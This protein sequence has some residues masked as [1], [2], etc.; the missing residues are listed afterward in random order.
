MIHKTLAIISLA[1]TLIMGA[2]QKIP[3]KDTAV[4]DTIKKDTLKTAKPLLPPPKKVEKVRLNIDPVLK[5]EPSKYVNFTSTKL[6]AQNGAI[7]FQ[8]DFLVLGEGI[9]GHFDLQTFD[10]TGNRLKLAQSEERNY[11][12]DQGSKFK[13]V[14]ISTTDTDSLQCYKVSVFFHEMRLEPDYGPCNR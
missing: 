1:A 3:P 7:N 9:F 5:I 12:R 11:R 10:S 8:G 2:D 6:T 13:N 4:A 14:L